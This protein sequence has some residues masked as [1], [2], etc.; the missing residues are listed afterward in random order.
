M[1]Q[2]RNEEKQYVKGNKR[3]K[4]MQVETNEQKRSLQPK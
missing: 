3:D 2:L 4:Q 1:I